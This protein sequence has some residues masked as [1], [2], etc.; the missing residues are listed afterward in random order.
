[1]VQNTAAKSPNQHTILLNPVDG[2]TEKLTKEEVTSAKKKIEVALKGKKINFNAINLRATNRGKIAVDLSS[3]EEIKAAIDQLNEVTGIIGFTA[4]DIP[5]KLPRLMIKN[6]PVEY[7]PENLVESLSDNYPL[8]NEVLTKN[9]NEVIKHIITL[10]NEHR[11]TSS[12]VIE[13]SPNVRKILMSE[14]K[15]K[16]GMCVYE[17]ADQLRVIQC[18]KCM[19][20][21]HGTKFCRSSVDVC[22]VCG[23]NHCTKNCPRNES[24]CNDISKSCSN[25]ANQR[26]FS[27]QSAN[28]GAGDK[29]K[30]P[31][32]LEQLERLKQQIDYGN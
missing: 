16:L 29:S 14:N 32:Y 18:G 5:K 23:N 8:I 11:Q 3:K 15:I 12:I 6:I 17:I 24:N 28:H 10:K 7:H 27:T 2:K 30:C 13:T 4:V 21:G 26:R 9:P 31:F 19:K 1:M 20:F 25:C 22:G